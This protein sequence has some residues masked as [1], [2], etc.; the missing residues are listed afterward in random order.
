MEFLGLC[1]GLGII[2]ICLV[3]VFLI[4]AYIKM[5]IE[6]WGEEE[7]KKKRKKKKELLNDNCTSIR[8]RNTSQGTR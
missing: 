4:C 1:V 2:I 8:K 7:P 5:A 6:R 3:Q